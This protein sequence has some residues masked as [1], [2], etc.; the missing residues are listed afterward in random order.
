M[1]TL[2]F[3][4]K[5]I[6]LDDFTL[7]VCET[8]ETVLARLGFTGIGDIERASLDCRTC[9]FLREA[10][11]RCTTPEEFDSSAIFVAPG[12]PEPG[13]PR[14]LDMLSNRGKTPGGEIVFS[15]SN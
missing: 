5:S 3:W 13:L 1:D 9:R 11:R 12:Y 2:T 4:S 6:K 14:S 7:P 8:C 15:K 10:I